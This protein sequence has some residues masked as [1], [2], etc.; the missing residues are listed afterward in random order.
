MWS[1]FSIGDVSDHGSATLVVGNLSE[2][3]DEYWWSH[4]ELSIGGRIAKNTPA[5]KAVARLVEG[6]VPGDQIDKAILK[7]AVAA[8]T[9]NK[10]MAIFAQIKE[11]A[12][13]D[14]EAHRAEVIREALAV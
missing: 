2:N 12:F 1:D 5:G 14:G 8:M 11:N 10:I 3:A 13:R 4:P 6:C 7:I 9:P